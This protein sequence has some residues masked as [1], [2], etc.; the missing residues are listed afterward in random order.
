M[1]LWLAVQSAALSV[2]AFRIPLWA[3]APANGEFLALK[4]LAIIQIGASSLLFPW[5][6]RNWRQ[7][8]MIVA[9]SWPFIAL[10]GL[11]SAEEL[12]SIGY[13]AV[14]VT[15]WLVV[16]IMLRIALRTS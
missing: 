7:S 14:F 4:L 5:L 6:M 2:A 3:Q 12:R 16:L 9:A 11:L 8:I 15:A 13:V 10:A 1:L